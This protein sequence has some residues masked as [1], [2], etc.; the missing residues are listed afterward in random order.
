M[1]GTESLEI[2]SDEIRIKEGTHA[3]TSRV[4]HKGEL[5]LMRKLAEIATQNGGDILEVGFG[6][7][8]SADAVQANPLVTSHTIIEV[9]PEIYKLALE[10]ARDKPNTKI[11]LGDWIDVIPKLTSK[12]D[13]IIHDTHLDQNLYKFLDYVKPSCKVGT[14]VGFFDLPV[15]DSRVNGHLH[16]LSKE[17]YESL[18]YRN[19]LAWQQNQFELKYTRFNGVDFERDKSVKSFI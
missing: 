16:K 9:H 2:S 12:F 11:I 3:P 10:W 17:E 5:S 14:V 18:P 15:K 13:G 19:H 8:L 6:L 4:M 7:H 1:K